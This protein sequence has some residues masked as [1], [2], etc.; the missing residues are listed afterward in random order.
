METATCIYCNKEFEYCDSDVFEY[1]DIIEGQYT[2][3]A[4]VKCPHC[5]R[6]HE[7]Y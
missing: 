6:T 1:S 3:F 7:L 5:E 2:E 4:G